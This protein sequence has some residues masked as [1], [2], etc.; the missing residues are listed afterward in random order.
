MTSFRIAVNVGVA[1]LLFLTPSFADLRGKLVF[2]SE[3]SCKDRGVRF[4]VKSCQMVYSSERC[5]VQYLNSATTNGLGA[6]DQERREMLER[7]LSGCTVAGQPVSMTEEPAGE[8]GQA[9]QM[10]TW[11]EVRI[12]AQNGGKILVRKSSGQEEW[13]DRADVRRSAS[14]P[15]S[16]ART[17]PAT[18]ASAAGSLPDGRYTCVGWIGSSAVTFGFVD[19]KGR[20]YRGPSHDVSGPFAPFSVAAGGA[21]TWSRGFGEFNSNGVRYQ[22][23]KIVPGNKPRFDVQYTTASGGA[24]VLNCER[25]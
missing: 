3:Y 17:T 1:G 21:L 14:S 18:N 11:Y 20:S 4:V 13:R 23:A 8:P 22:S 19:I 9:V 10:G 16:S 24:E 25:E 7:R 2:G 5:D 15:S 12:L 6:L